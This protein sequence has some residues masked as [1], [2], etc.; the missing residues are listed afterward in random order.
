MTSFESSKTLGGI[1]ALLLFVSVIASVLVSYG[2]L[3][4]GAVGLILLLIGLH[5]LAEYY[6]DHSI[7]SNALYAFV[8]AIIGIITAVGVIVG[9]VLINLDKLKTFVTQIYPGWNGD[10]A[11]LQN[12]TPDT[13]ALQS[14]TIDYSIILP[15]L[16]GILATAVVVWVFAII[17]TF[18]ARKSLRTVSEKSTVGLFGTAGLLMLIGAVLIIALGLGLLLIWIGTLILAIA[19][20]QLRPSAPAPVYEQ[21]PP[22][23]PA[24]TF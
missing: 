22:P 3:V 4:L 11:S 20:F 2:G 9:T 12:M 14:G 1:G 10:W 24:A 15:I 13:N 21:A 17:S 5:G 23:P 19:F 6:H 18:F 7:Y 8:A 16:I